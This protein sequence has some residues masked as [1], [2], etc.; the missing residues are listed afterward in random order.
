MAVA[1]EKSTKRRVCGSTQGSFTLG[2][3]EE[4]KKKSDN[5]EEKQLSSAGEAFLFHLIDKNPLQPF[6]LSAV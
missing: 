5:T 3:G 4:K 2:D 6:V 1:L